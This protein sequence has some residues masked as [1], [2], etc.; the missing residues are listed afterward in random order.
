MKYIICKVC[1]DNI[2]LI[3]LIAKQAKFNF[4]IIWKIWYFQDRVS[5]VI[6]LKNFV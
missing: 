2:D 3:Y 5:S 6:N 4:D 1:W